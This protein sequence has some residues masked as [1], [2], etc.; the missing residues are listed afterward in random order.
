MQELRRVI[1]PYVAFSDDAILE[2]ATPQERTPEERTEAPIPV[3]TQAA[4][5]EEPTD[6]LAPA[7]VS[8]EEVAPMEEPDEETAALMAM[9]S[10]P[11]E[12]PDVPLCSMRRKKRG[13]YPIATFLAG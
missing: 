4:P 3:E 2:G 10:G 8:M 9:V 7:E 5:M 13:R 6:E 11:A 12:E 1:E